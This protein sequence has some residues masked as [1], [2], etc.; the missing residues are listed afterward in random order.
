MQ[1]MFSTT[2]LL[3]VRPYL[4]VICNVMIYSTGEEVLILRFCLQDFDLCLLSAWVL[5]QCLP[6]FSIQPLCAS[7]GFLC[8]HTNQQRYSEGM[9]RNKFHGN[10]THS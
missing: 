5:P 8:L 1:E 6:T 10:T 4:S 2:L 7:L 9:G 3:R